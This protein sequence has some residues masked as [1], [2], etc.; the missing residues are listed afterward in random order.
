MANTIYTS[1]QFTD[2]TQ[3]VLTNQVAKKKASLAE[4]Q[5]ISESAAKYAGITFQL[6]KTAF[7]Q[8]LRSAGITKSLRSKMIKDFGKHFFDKMLEILS[9]NT[10]GN[11][12]ELVM[13]VDIRKKLIVSFM[14]SEHDMISNTTFIPEMERIISD[15]NLDS[16]QLRPSQER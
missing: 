9:A 3:G 1:S 12:S 4:I 14:K 5:V 8:L 7:Q 15:N 16:H 13:V 6:S 11:N 2:F 10:K